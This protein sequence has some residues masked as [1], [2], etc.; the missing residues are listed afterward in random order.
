MNPKENA[1]RIV[2]FDSPERI[3]S[4]M[5]THDISYFGVNHEPFEGEGGHGSP[6]GTQW[7]D[8]WGVGWRKEMEGVMGY[9]VHHPLADL[10]VE[11]YGWP[12]PDDE[13][14][15]KQVYERA[16][17]PEF[18]PEEQF[19][20]GSHRETLWERA[21]NLVGMD[22]LMMAFFDAPDAVREIFRRI[23]DFQLGIARHYA[24][25]G[26]EIASTGGDLGTQVG[27]LVG[28][29]IMHEFMVPEWKRLIAF[30]SERG[31]LIGRHCC[32]HVEPILDMFME[33]GID[34]L[35]PIQATANDLARVRGATAGKMALA[36]GVSTGIVMD[37]PP[38]RIR[39]EARRCMWL[40]GR[41]GGYFCSP[42]QGMPF[43]E[44]HIAA[45]R[46]EVESYG[47]YPLKPPEEIR[48]SPAA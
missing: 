27:L 30:Y 46:E 42:D 33:L 32:G 4:G 43:P 44:E 41:E 38:E 24:K 18:N 16:R 7:R 29:E 39:A 13:R 20:R 48:E 31:V 35:N 1:L 36:G 28:P 17:D 2:R 14:L 8:I 19:V 47:V 25:C 12:D 21:Y 34:V 22:R 26:I 23:T 10:D 6:V 40:L 11:R 37:G 5:P 15:V 9:A 3:A 45:L